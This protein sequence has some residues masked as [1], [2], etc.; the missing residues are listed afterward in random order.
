MKVDCKTKKLR[1]QAVLSLFKYAIKLE[2][3]NT[4]LSCKLI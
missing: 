4:F 2:F 1:P 3:N